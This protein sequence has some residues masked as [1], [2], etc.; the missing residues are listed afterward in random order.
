MRQVQ[1]KLIAVSFFIVNLLIIAACRRS[2]PTDIRSSKAQPNAQELSLTGQVF[3]TLKDRETVKLSLTNI[4]L[5]DLDQARS[6]GINIQATRRKRIDEITGKKTS[7]QDQVASLQAQLAPLKERYND[8]D[9]QLLPLYTAI[10]KWSADTYK[11]KQQTD[12]DANAYDEKRA[13]LQQAIDQLHAIT[14]KT[15]SECDKLNQKISELESSIEEIDKELPS[16]ADTTNYLDIKQLKPILKTTTDADG[17][18]VIHL[19]G[20]SAYAVA[21]Y[22]ER[23]SAGVVEKYA[24]L[25]E[26]DPH[27]SDL[28]LNNNNMVD[29]DD[30]HSLIPR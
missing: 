19:P 13:K 18:Y 26:I 17:R 28:P 21:A 25:L 8:A 24:W 9:K 4:Y 14:W 2:T 7:F 16:A 5:L 6:L 3:V 29:S 30:P 12:F 11:A 20:E 10:V 15:Q 27:Q 22:T 23:E 1:S